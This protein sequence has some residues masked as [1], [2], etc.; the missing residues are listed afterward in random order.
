MAAG[1]N[2]GHILPAKR[3]CKRYWHCVVPT[4]FESSWNRDGRT[5]IRLPRR[6]SV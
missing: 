6:V 4:T 5:R 1:T 3:D 2:M